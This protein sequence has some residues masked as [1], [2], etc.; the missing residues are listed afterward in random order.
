MH[1]CVFSLSSDS[2]I[3]RTV[4]GIGY[5][6]P[7]FLVSVLVIFERCNNVVITSLT[8]FMILIIIE[9]M[10]VFIERIRYQKVDVIIICI[11]IGYLK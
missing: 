6:W 5:Y 1:I 9:K 3:I 8:A 10:H 2:P 11:G 7:L 4:I